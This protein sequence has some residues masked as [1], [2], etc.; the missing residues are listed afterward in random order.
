MGLL[1]DD[2]AAADLSMTLSQNKRAPGKG[3]ITSLFA[4]GRAWPALP[5]REHYATTHNVMKILVL[6][7]IS[8]FG[9]ELGAA[10]PSKFIAQESN[11]VRDYDY[12]GLEP[13]ADEVIKVM[14][15]IVVRVSDIVRDYDYVRARAV[16]TNAL[17]TFFF[18]NWPEP[19]T[20]SLF[21]D[22]A[23]SKGYV[24]VMDGTNLVAEGR[25]FGLAYH[26]KREGGTLLGLMLKFDSLDDAQDAATAIRHDWD[27]EIHRRFEDMRRS[28]DDRKTWR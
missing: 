23:P 3:G 2:S 4:A 8:A 5:E 19:E 22:A 20:E 1:P 26:Q 6:A 17:L 28:F 11:I 9:L 13:G 12:F 21:S 24:Q 18:R 10:E 25:I 27:T 14:A 7:V 16:Q 15:P